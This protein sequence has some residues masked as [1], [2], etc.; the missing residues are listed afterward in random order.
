MNQSLSFGF[1]MTL[2]ISSCFLILHL[3][4]LIMKAQDEI[5]IRLFILFNISVVLPLISS[6][7]DYKFRKYLFSYCISKFGL[8]TVQN[9]KSFLS[10]IFTGNLIH[11]VIA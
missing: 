5:P 2:I 10:L 7:S 4:A 3:I 1:G 11:P 6:L 8:D 9:V